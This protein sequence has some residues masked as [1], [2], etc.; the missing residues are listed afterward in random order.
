ML[1]IPAPIFSTVVFTSHY[2]V[3]VSTCFN[4][5]Q[6]SQIGGFQDF[7]GPSTVLPWYHHAISMIESSTSSATRFR[8]PVLLWPS[9]D[10][11]GPK[12]CVEVFV[13]F[14]YYHEKTE[15]FGTYEWDPF[16]L[17]LCGIFMGYLVNMMVWWFSIA[18]L[19]YQMVCRV[20]LQMAG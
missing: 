7:A 19:N 3:W 9:I 8:H 2:F 16:V 4:I 1:H 6:P 15:W 20:C 11:H 10:R 12:S 13:L 17:F 5:F 14:G 18:M